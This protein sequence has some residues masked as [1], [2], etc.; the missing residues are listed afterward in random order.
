MTNPWLAASPDGLVYY[1]QADPS[2]G[3]VE[4]KN[5]F[6]VRDKTLEEAVA[7][8]KTF[9]LT[10]NKD[11][12]L[13]LKKGHDYY[14]QMLCAMFCTNCHWC[15][16]VVLTKSLHIERIYADPEFKLKTLPKL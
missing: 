15:D 4:F 11:G 14:H 8:C 3:L 12:K 7:S 2:Q 13:E 9:C 16:L 6:S 1:P 5:P 10:K